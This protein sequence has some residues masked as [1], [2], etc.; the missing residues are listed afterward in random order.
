M[1][2]AFGLLD[3]SIARADGATD[4]AD[5]RAATG[6]TGKRPFDEETFEDAYRR[7]FPVIVA[8]CKRMLGGTSEA[9]D[10]AQEAFARLWRCRD[11]LPG[12]PAVAAWL[13]R[14]CTRLAI[15]KLR[16]RRRGLGL[17]LG[18]GADSLVGRLVADGGS[19][20]G[21]SSSRQLLARL[22]SAIS[23]QDLEVAILSRVDGLTHGEMAQV[24]AISERTVRRRLVRFTVRL[25]RFLQKD[26]S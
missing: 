20:E 21:S 25:A 8:K 22:S 9:Q 15:D 11:P 19:P 23:V 3:G 26:C 6:S 13:Y 2:W 4:P 18:D 1:A 16:Q 10:V 17:G 7:Y 12:D 24:L 14:T 5:A